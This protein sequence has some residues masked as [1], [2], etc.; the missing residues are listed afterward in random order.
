MKPDNPGCRRDA[1]RAAALHG[2]EGFGLGS[3]L[4][5]E[6]VADDHAA[7]GRFDRKINS[8]SPPRELPRAFGSPSLSSFTTA[9]IRACTHKSSSRV[10]FRA[11]QTLERTSPNDR[12]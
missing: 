5:S 11:K 1:R 12:V 10:H 9:Q 6:A 2:V 8:T 7:A 3:F 4:G